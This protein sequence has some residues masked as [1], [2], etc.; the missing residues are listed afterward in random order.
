V[1]EFEAGTWPPLASVSSSSSG[2]EAEE[3]ASS[4]CE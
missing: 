4:R 3:G 1:S 2:D